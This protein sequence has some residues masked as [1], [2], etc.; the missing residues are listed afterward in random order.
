[1]SMPAPNPLNINYIDPDG[2]NWSLSDLSFSAGIVC[3]AIAGI[4]GLPVMLQTIPLLDGT[5]VPN[6]YI[7]QPG[8]IAIGLLVGWP[9]G[10]YNEDD[11]YANLDSIVRA[12]TNR[13]NELPAAGY[14]Q[15]QRPNGLTRQLTV[16]CTSGLNTPEVGIHNTLYSLTLQ[17]PDPYW[18]DLTP[19]TVSYS[20]NPAVG[21]LPL[22]PITFSGQLLGNSLLVNNGTALAFPTWT[23]TGPGTPTFKNLTTG[24]QFSLNTSIPSGNVVQV[25]TKPGSQAVVNLTTQT[26]IWD[27][28]VLS[29]LRDLW[30]LV[31]GTNQVSLVMAG[32]SSSSSVQVQWVNRW[33]RALWPLSALMHALSRFRRRRARSCLACFTIRR[34]LARWSRSGSR[35]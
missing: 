12:F 8:S 18:Y 4:E 28:L 16:F 21:I 5:A 23:I 15:V 2:N 34:R 19:Q 26:N 35:Y 33:S 10:S 30:P 17:A 29:S 13:R 22:L 9:D 27:Q 14:L 20:N 25:T 24:R 1:M 31:G 7:P 11:Y 32:S 6:I 3:A